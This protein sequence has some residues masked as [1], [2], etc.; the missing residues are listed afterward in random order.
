[1]PDLDKLAATYKDRGV[2]VLDGVRRKAR[3]DP[4][5]HDAN[6]RC[7]S[8]T[9]AIFEDRSPEDWI[10]KQAYAGRPT[11]VLIGRDGK[12]RRLLIGGQS[13]DRFEEALL[14]LL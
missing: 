4:E 2:V 12:V 3:K 14:P 9:F 8:L 11:T 5:V 1:M 10:G 6:I 13:Y 7:P